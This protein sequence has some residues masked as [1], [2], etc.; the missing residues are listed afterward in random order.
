MQRA[1]V[2]LLANEAGLT[3]PHFSVDATTADDA[4]NSQT[5]EGLVALYSLD[6]AST[7]RASE[8]LV[9]VFPGLTVECNAEPVC[10]PRLRSLAQ[11]A[12]LFIFAWKAS[13]HAAY[14]CVK[15]GVREKDVLVMAP[16]KGTSSLLDAATR[17][18]GR[19]SAS[20]IAERHGR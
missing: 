12:E 15:A 5:P 1:F 2:C 20:S 19:L 13:K 10:T 8:L 16:G 7:R 11:R 14:D 17:H 6:E 3:S 9:S 4:E 18:I